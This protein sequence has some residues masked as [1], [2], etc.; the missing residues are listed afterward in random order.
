MVVLNLAV[1]LF[2]VS[3]ASCRSITKRSCMYPIVAEAGD[4][5]ASL[6]TYWGITVDQFISY[7]PTIGPGCSPGVVAGREYCVEQDP[8]AITTTSR[9]STVKFTA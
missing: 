4:T 6:S 2:L 7:N 3:V 9:T 8:A 1:G 5:C